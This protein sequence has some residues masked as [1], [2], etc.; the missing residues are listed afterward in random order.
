MYKLFELP[1]EKI[2]E[3][4]NKEPKEYRHLLYGIK[5]H[6]DSNKNLSYKREC[7]LLMRY[8]KRQWKEIEMLKEKVEGLELDLCQEKGF[9]KEYS[10]RC[11]EAIEYIDKVKTLAEV[12][13]VNIL[14]IIA[15]EKIL[16][17]SD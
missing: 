2:Y 6:A 10:T 16:Q 1:E 4:M 8:L 15:L 17:G 9:V 11:L 12:D 13:K 14:S 5:I 7:K 3:I